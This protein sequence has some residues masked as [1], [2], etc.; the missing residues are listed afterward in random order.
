MVLASILAGAGCQSEGGGS[1]APVTN[2]T[3]GSGG[4]SASGGASGRGGS[5]GGAGQGQG[6]GQ[7]GGGS[8]GAAPS[9]DGGPADSGGDAAPACPATQLVCDPSLKLPRSIKETGLYPAA[10]DLSRVA[11]RLVPFQPGLELWSNGLHKQRFLLLPPGGKVDN[12][13]PKR[14]DFPVGTI[15]VKTFLHDAAGGQRPVETRLIRKVADPVEPFEFSV[16]RWNAE[17]TDAQLADITDPIPV[18]VTVAG[19]SF[20]HEIPSKIHCGDC[21]TANAQFASAVIGF[22]EIRLAGKRQPSDPEIQLAALAKRD[23]F[24]RPPPATPAAI[25]DANPVLQRVKRFMFGQCVHC[26]NGQGANPIDLRPEVFVA[27]T[28][29]KLPESPGVEAPPGYQRI[30]PRMPERSVVYLQTLGGNLPPTLRLMPPVGVQIRDLPEFQ[31][32]LDNL[33]AWINGLP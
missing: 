22:D 2:P 32:E 20:T 11:E 21:H 5:G 17:G 14:W 10:P 16:Y 18:P 26:H 15:L 13:D 7:G 24:T 28:V 12:A 1:P 9:A 19:R 4:Q 6:Q 33:K 8:D 25:S 3:A 27:N 29:G 23:L 31:T 30:R